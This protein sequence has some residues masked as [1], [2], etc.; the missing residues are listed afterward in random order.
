MQAQCA[1]KSISSQQL[2]PCK[3]IS[4]PQAVPSQSL[5]FLPSKIV[6]LLRGRGV[7][8]IWRRLR[9]PSMGT[10]SPETDPA[11]SSD[12]SLAPPRMNDAN[13]IKLLEDVYVALLEKV[14]HITYIN[15]S[16]ALI[17]WEFY[18]THIP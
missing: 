6:L 17:Q 15:R 3:Q 10:G 1:S 13:K 5:T 2:P 4:P 16:T 7:Q 14:L 9:H 8:L 11:G 12:R 18:L